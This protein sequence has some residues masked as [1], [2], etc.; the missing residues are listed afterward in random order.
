[1]SSCRR[2]PK[3]LCQWSLERFLQTRVS[4]PWTH[5]WIN[6]EQRNNSLYER[7]PRHIHP[8]GA[9][10]SSVVMTLKVQAGVLDDFWDKK[11]RLIKI[12]VTDSRQLFFEILNFYCMPQSQRHVWGFNKLFATLVHYLICIMITIVFSLFDLSFSWFY[13]TITFAKN[14]L[15]WNGMTCKK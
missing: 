9:K 11:K 15:K 12:G 4:P 3:Y 5:V 1:M 2:A 8:E 10:L 14:K 13:F 6:P 7:R